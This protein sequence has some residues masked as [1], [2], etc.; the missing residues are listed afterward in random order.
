ML[1]TLALAMKFI[2]VANKVFKD[3]FYIFLLYSI[4]YTWFQMC[5]IT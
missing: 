1:H 5:F 2:P 4:C 3:L